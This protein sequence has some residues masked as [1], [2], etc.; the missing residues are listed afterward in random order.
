MD[1]EFRRHEDPIFVYTPRH[2]TDPLRITPNMARIAIHSKYPEWPEDEEQ[3]TELGR[4]VLTRFP[5]KSYSRRCEECNA[6]ASLRI[7]TMFEPLEDDLTRTNICKHC[8][9]E[10]FGEFERMFEQYRDEIAADF[11]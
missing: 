7:Y 4:L 1:V 8:T 9:E 11:L 3:T 10:L 6:D 2:G 5:Q